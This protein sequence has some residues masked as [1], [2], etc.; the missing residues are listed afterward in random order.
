MAEMN[1]HTVAQELIPGKVKEMLN[2]ITTQFVQ[3]VTNSAHLYIA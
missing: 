2:K 3:K 1:Q